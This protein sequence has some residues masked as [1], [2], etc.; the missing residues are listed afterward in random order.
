[1]LVNRGTLHGP[2]LPI[3]GWGCTIIILL[4]RFKKFREIL[5]NPV[6]TFIIIVIVCSIIE[7]MTSWYIELVSGLRYWDYTGVFLN[8]NGR[9]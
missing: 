2:W 4:T 3:Y 1:M 7:Y 8:L 9:I 5:K 6:L